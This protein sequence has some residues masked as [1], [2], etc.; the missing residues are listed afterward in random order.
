[1]G[2]DGSDLAYSGKLGRWLSAQRAVK[3]G[4]K[5]KKLTEDQEAQLQALVDQGMYVLLLL[6]VVVVVFVL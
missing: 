2:E 5:G 3:K 6:L 1:M 4:K